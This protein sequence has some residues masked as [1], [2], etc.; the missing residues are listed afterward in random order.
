MFFWQDIPRKGRVEMTTQET[1]KSISRSEQKRAT[2]QKLI[3]TTIDI[4]ASEGL[5]K[6]TLP[7]V[8]QK[9]GLSRGICNFHFQTKE[10]LL[11]ETFEA[12]YME[13]EAAWKGALVDNSEPPV[14]RIEKFV[15]VLLT[16]PVADTRK[17]SVWLA[18]WGETPWRKT[19][20]KLCTD[21]DLEFETSVADILRKI[22]G[23]S[24]KTSGMS[25]QSVAVGLTGMIDGF[26]I[27][28]LIA[29]NRLKPED[30]I[31]ACLAYLSSFFPSF[32]E[33]LKP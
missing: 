21:T 12:V 29:P 33:R 13:F 3:D 8:A 22:P 14:A 30:A 1:A 25:L 19:Y 27:Q 24:L 28:Y 10:Q 15:Q 7:K 16:P 9:A 31:L 26:W 32:R 20:L 6:T 2:R 23:D 11:L 4:I 17:I 18:Y 5:S